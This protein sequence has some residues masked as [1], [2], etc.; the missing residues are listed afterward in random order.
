MRTLVTDDDEILPTPVAARLRREGKA[1]DVALVGGGAQ[2][3][4]GACRAAVSGLIRVITRTGV[5]TTSTSVRTTGRV[6]RRSVCP[7][8][9]ATA[10]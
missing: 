8:A 10:S 5:A 2:G 6:T 9:T 7:I 1:V 3:G 4:S